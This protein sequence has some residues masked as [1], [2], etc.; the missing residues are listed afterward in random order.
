LR[1]GRAGMD[2]LRRRT[3]Q[4]SPCENIALRGA[5]LAYDAPDLASWHRSIVADHEKSSSRPS[6]RELRFFAIQKSLERAVGLAALAEGPSGKR[7]SHQRR[8]PMSVLHESRRQ[9]L[10]RIDDLHNAS[11][12]EDLHNVAKQ[13]NGTITGI[14]K[15]TVYDTAL[16][17]AGHRGLEPS[18]VFL[19]A[20][21]REGARAFAID[22]FRESISVDE[23]PSALRRLKPREVEDCLCVYKNDF[24]RLK[25]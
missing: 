13:T 4:F 21:T 17:I 18:H 7:V 1:S 9:L 23:L 15:L 3:P 25:A 2:R 24:R 16:R 12:F 22:G 11:T 5:S 6:P 19:H 20:G 14:G 8:I 10:A